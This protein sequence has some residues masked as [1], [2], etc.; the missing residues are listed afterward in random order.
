MGRFAPRRSAEMECGIRN[1]TRGGVRKWNAGSG[2]QPGAECGNGMRDQELD[3]GRSAEMECGMR[4]SP[5]GGV[6]KWNAGSGTRPGASAE[7][8]C[9]I[10]TTTRGGVRKWNAGSGFRPGA[11]CGN[12]MR[13]RELDPGRSTEKEREGGVRW[14]RVAPALR[15]PHTSRM[16]AVPTSTFRLPRTASMLRSGSQIPLPHSASGR[17]PHPAFHFRTPPRGEIRIPHSS[18]A[19]RLGARSASRIPFP[20]SPRVEFLIPRSISALRLG[21]RSASR[22]PFPHPAPGRVPDPAFHLRTPPRVEF[23]RLRINSPVTPPSA[24]RETHPAP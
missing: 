14:E 16:R 17:D 12:G 5:R 15:I 2:P 10:G 19:L 20:H 18:S 6:R 11:E 13:D 8:E 23:T 24:S 4:I 7:K 22:I 9:G 1:S 3:P 21:A